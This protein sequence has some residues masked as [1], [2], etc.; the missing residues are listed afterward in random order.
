MIKMGWTE[1]LPT[2]ACNGCCGSCLLTAAASA[3]S[4][5]AVRPHFGAL[6]EGTD[7]VLIVLV[8]HVDV[9]LLVADVDKVP[10]RPAHRL[11]RSH[12]QNQQ[13]ARGR[14]AVGELCPAWHQARVPRAPRSPGCSFCFEVVFEGGGGIAKVRHETHGRHHLVH[15]L[16]AQIIA[17]NRET[18]VRISSSD[19]GAQ[20]AS[21]GDQQIK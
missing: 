14:H 12:A 6:F 9:L 13:R 17:D 2:C 20:E 4:W 21:P 15:L 5:L 19:D 7:Q 16:E 8:P 10:P 1:Y 11:V 3:A 18:Q